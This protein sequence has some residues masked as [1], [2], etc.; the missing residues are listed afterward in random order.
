MRESFRHF[1]FMN[2]SSRARS[3]SRPAFFFANSAALA[4]SFSR[5]TGRGRPRP[6]SG[7][8]CDQLDQ[9]QENLQAA[10]AHRVGDE[11][12]DAIGSEAH[13]RRG[14]A[15]HDLVAYLKNSEQ[16]F[17]RFPHAGEGE[18]EKNGEKDDLQEVTFGQGLG[19]ASK[20]G[21]AS[22]RERV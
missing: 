8:D 12:A 6:R 11:R 18:A 20:I 16:R 7:R 17:P 10:F 19:G 5:P 2:S 9:R 15:D 22:C 14:D 4:F 3:R 13:N 1:A 21:R